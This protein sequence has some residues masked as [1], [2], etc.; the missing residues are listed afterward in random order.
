MNYSLSNSQM[1]SNGML[2][3]FL[4]RTRNAIFTH[5]KK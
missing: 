3:L 4:Y 5:F 2:Q 1:K